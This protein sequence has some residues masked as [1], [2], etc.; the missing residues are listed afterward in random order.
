MADQQNE[1][2][3]Q[4]KDAEPNDEVP[5]PIGEVTQASVKN[6]QK[7]QDNESKSLFR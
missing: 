3:I 6:Q 7:N 4:S 1:I 5:R 2:P